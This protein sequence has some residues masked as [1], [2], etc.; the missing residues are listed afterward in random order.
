VSDDH[1]TH[2]VMNQLTTDTP[3]FELVLGGVT[4]RG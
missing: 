4:I 1:T 3:L 2:S